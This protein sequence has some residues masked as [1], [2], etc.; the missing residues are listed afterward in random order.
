VIIFPDSKPSQVAKKLN[1][2]I[3]GGEI[4]RVEECRRFRHLR[5]LMQRGFR[6]AGI[7]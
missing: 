3:Y 2:S 5:G 6:N 7:G 1:P 4:V